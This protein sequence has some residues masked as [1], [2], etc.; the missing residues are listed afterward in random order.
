ME[1]FQ[2]FTGLLWVFAYLSIA[3]V[4]FVFF[5]MLWG[6]ESRI[7]IFKR[8]AKE[9]GLTFKTEW[10]PLAFLLLPGERYTARSLKGVM[11]GKNVV[12]EDRFY[13]HYP[14]NELYIYAIFFGY[15]TLPII[16]NY[17]PAR[18]SETTVLTVND[19]QIQL[20]EENEIEESLPGVPVLDPLLTPLYPLPASY[21]QIKEALGSIERL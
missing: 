5:R 6:K 11:H 13:S 10:Y 21:T 9:Y 7:S 16:S 17:I 14:N 15:V 20:N 2:L 1:A 19:E 12:L 4:G 3:F 8:I 18:P